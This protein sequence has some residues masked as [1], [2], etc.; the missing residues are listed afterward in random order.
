M[1][2]HIA[3]NYTVMFREV[4]HKVTVKNIEDMMEQLYAG[5]IIRV[6]RVEQIPAII[7]KLEQRE[8]LLSRLERAEYSLGRSGK[9]PTMNT[10]YAK[11]YD[12]IQFLKEEL[13]KVHSFVSDRYFS[14]I[15]KS[16]MCQ[17]IVKS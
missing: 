4:P 5:K 11:N 15:I 9:R 2:Q 3:S 1:R 6:Y 16:K 8:K 7:A 13:T 17:S 14:C 12:T 10:K